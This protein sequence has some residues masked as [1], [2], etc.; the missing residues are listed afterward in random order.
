MAIVITE[1]WTIEAGLDAETGLNKRYVVDAS[2]IQK[3]RPG[4]TKPKIVIHLREQIYTT[5]DGVDKVVK[6]KT[7]G[8][9][10]I[11]GVN[12]TYYDGSLMPKL[13]ELGNEIQ[14]TNENG[15]PVF[16]ADG[17]T[18]VYV[19]GRDDSYERVVH[20]LENGLFTKQTLLDGNKEYYKL[21]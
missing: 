18:P 17:V 12:R 1:D 3:A 9:E 2:T 10:I 4:V 15:D 19:L 14:E 5:V 13:D 11:R 6:D 7:A 21:V 8:Y 20:A 16:E